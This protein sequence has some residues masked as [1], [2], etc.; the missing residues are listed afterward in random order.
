M[1]RSSLIAI[2]LLFSLRTASAIPEFYPDR[3]LRQPDGTIFTVRIYADEFGRYLTTVGGYV[4]Q[5]PRDGYY[6]Y[7]HIAKDGTTAPSRFKVGIDD[8]AEAEEIARLSEQSESALWEIARWL[9]T[10]EG[11]EGYDEDFEPYLI[12][13]W[14][15][16]RYDELRHQPDGTTFTVQVFMDG[17]GRYLT[18]KGKYVIQ[19]RKDGYYYYARI[20]EDGTATPSRL[21]V[22]MDDEA[23]ELAQ[24]HEQSSF[25]VRRLSDRWHHGKEVEAY[26][27]L[28]IGYGSPPTAV[29]DVSWGTIKERHTYGLVR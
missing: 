29:R 16:H 14:V 27:D 4:I 1:A 2:A 18:V 26:I 13:L 24:L 19:D 15:S 25:A 22:G 17:V 11:Y 7:A 23:E 5:D 20:A 12:N 3:D 9:H 8:E 6:Y 28:W 10:G 21:K